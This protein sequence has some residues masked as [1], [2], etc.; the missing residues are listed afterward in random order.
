MY[1]GSAIRFVPKCRDAN[2]GVSFKK[3]RE[4]CGITGFS[5]DYSE[6]LL[7]GMND[8]ITHR[9]PDASGQILLEDGSHR[10]GLAHRR[11]SIVDLSSAGRQ[12]MTVDCTA[13]GCQHDLADRQKL[14][15]SFN[16]EIYNFLELRRELETRG[17]RFSSRTDSE[18]LLHLYAE[19]G[20]EMLKRLNGIFALAIYDG[21]QSQGDLLLARDGLGVKP[22]YLTQ[23]PR[24]V[25]FSSELKSLLAAPDV[26]RTLDLQGLNQYLTYLY[27]CAPR[28]MFRSV[29]KLE[30]G[31]ATLI[32]LR[33]TVARW[34]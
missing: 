21:R 22:L 15:L 18:V 28:T 4:M 12:P 5:G 27:S 16:G 17:H 10:V 2:V 1:A 25:L 33:T 6:S 14:W 19:H 11:L 3:R 7:T 13:C 29:R 26:D 23:T 9:G 32:A 20:P 31:H 30:P 8:R 24:G 34:V